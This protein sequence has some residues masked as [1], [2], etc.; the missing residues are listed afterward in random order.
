MRVQQLPRK[1]IQRKRQ[2][3][4]QKHRQQQRRKQRQKRITCQCGASLET[5]NREQHVY[6][7]SNN[8]G[9]ITSSRQLFFSTL[10]P[11]HT[12]VQTSAR[13]PARESHWKY[14]VTY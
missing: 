6:G 8:P 12:N 13:A 9:S 7:S 14:A 10:A 5:H 3:Q 4:Q 11:W 1:P 2:Q